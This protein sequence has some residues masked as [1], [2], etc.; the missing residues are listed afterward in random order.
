[1]GSRSRRPARGAVDRAVDVDCGGPPRVSPYA[2]PHRARHFSIG[3]RPLLPKNYATFGFIPYESLHKVLHTYKE[4]VHKIPQADRVLVNSIEGIEGPAIDSL[5]GSG[6]N[7]KHIGP[8]HLLSDKLGTSAQQGVDCK[9]ESSAIIQWLGARP[10]SSVI[11]I[12]FGTTMPVADGQFEEL[13][14]ALEESR[15]EFVWAIRDS[16][17]IPPGFQER[18]TK[19]DQG[20]VVSWAP[21]LEILGHRSVGGFLTH[22]GWNSVMESMSFGMPMVARPITG[23]QVL[24]AKFVID[25]WGIGVGVRGIEMGRELARKD[26]L[27]NSIKALMEADPKTSEIWK[28]ARRV[29]EVVRAAMKNKGSSRNNIDSLV[30]KRV[31]AKCH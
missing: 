28:N 23:D 31:K 4:L 21:Q 22:C 13:A 29:K 15:Q 2:T 25:E 27:K 1:M 14:S 6:I 16:S 19:L 3:R 18:M 9:K 30:H 5:I 7:I 20:L 8:L 17:L 10:D 11:Y 12:A 24:T 26:D